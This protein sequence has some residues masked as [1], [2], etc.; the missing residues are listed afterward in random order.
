MQAQSSPILPYYGISATKSIKKI[1]TAD[2]KSLIIKK[3][4]SL[5]GEA[6]KQHLLTFQILSLGFA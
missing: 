1:M 2:L 4:F 5:I 6:K 3:M